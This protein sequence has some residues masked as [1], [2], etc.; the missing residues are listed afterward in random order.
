MEEA[1]RHARLHGRRN[2]LQ[3]QQHFSAADGLFPD[4][5]ASGKHATPTPASDHRI[6]N[7]FEV[8]ARAHSFP[9]NLVAADVRRLIPFG[10]NQVGA[11]LRRLLRFR[12]SMREVSRGNL[13][14]GGKGEWTVLV[15]RKPICLA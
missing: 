3:H 12:D 5:T 11:S 8:N 10:R 9:R 15:Y 7:M 4:L 1:E 14:P 6:S 2:R 13:S